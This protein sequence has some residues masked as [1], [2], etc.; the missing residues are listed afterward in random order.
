MSTPR[1]RIRTPEGILFS[2]ELAGPAPRFLAWLID[3]A[4]LMAL[5]TIVNIGVGF[6]AVL[7]PELAQ[8]IAIL[9]GFSINTG[10]KIITE[11]A[12]RGQTFGKRA[13]RLRV[14]DVEGM[15]LR[16]SQVVLRN[17]LRA[18]DML[19]GLYLLGG[20]T[21]ALSPRAQRLGDLAAGTTV[22]RIPKL[23][24]PDIDQLVAGKFNSLRAH[25]HLIARLRQQVS[26]G[27]ASIALQCLLR[28]EDFTPEARVQLY[29][30]VASHFR[31]L[32]PFPP[33]AT[34]GLADEQ[35]LRN[36]VDVLYRTRPS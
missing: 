21:A 35:Y 28:R 34:E 4:V 17:L 10:Y 9:L 5:M 6:F 29:S 14:V 25:P 16:F 26:P 18:V 13:L 31:S 7:S 23:Q 12:W 19:P 11:W 33:E 15:R 36:L 20:L 1:L 2:Q 27:D 32:V 24:Q 30:E 22:V 3:L 8:G